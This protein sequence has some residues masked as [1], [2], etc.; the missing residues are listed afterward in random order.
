MPK[1]SIIIRTKNEERWIS[2]CLAAVFKQDFQ[3]FEVILVDNQSTDKTIDKAKLYNVNIVSLNDFKPGKAIN[4]G[5][6]QSKGE[7]IC[8]LSGH[9]IPTNNK[10]LSNLV[11]SIIPPDVAGVYGRQEPLSYS[12]DF[13]KR[14]LLITF[15]LD[16]KVQIKDPFF[17][18]ANS[19]IKRS[20]WEKIPFDEQVTNI[21]DRVWGKQVLTQGYKIIYEPEASVYHY[22]GIHQSS[23]E[24]RCRKI[25]GILET[26]ENGHLNK[27]LDPEKLNCVAVIPLKG[28]IASLG[29]RPLLD[30]TIERALA[31][32][33]IKQIV[34]TCD[35]DEYINLAKKHKK[36][37]CLKRPPEFSQDY[38][39][40]E[41][42][43]K[44]TVEVLEQQA[45]IPDVVVYLSST[46]PFRPKN[47]IDQTI[48][49]LVEEGFDSVLPAIPEYKSCWREEEGKLVRLD[50]GFVPSK[51]KN[52]LH[53]GIS[54]LCTATY[55]EFIRRGERL[56]PK[57]GMLEIEGLIHML[58]VSKAN[59]FQVAE[60][61]ISD[62]WKNNDK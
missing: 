16:R 33:Y 38:I 10:W 34:L 19:L 22:H 55:S 47:I 23:D 49:M 45:I 31:S 28:E 27:N 17:H 26:F 4:Y 53:I 7:Y 42:I 56:G 25:V 12:S 9:C 15:G 60:Q 62:W 32:R 21:E 44:Y 48:R 59:D 1:V 13:D 6:K 40:I 41:E 57:V 8:C 54:G 46:Y 35:N 36:I 43:L 24:E 20:V 61:L 30:Y 39:E 11:N 2:S 14:D 51:Y 37:I 29:G 58:N 18:N 3:D 50:E 5:I 52:P